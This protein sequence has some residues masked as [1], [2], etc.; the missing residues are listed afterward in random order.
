MTD[1]NRRDEFNVEPVKESTF[2]DSGFRD[3]EEFMRESTDNRDYV[4][5]E[6]K[7]K[8]RARIAVIAAS[9]VVVLAL[10]IIVFKI[11]TTD[12]SSGNTA[13]TPSPS[14]NST[15]TAAP[16][17]D[18][19][20]IVSLYPQ[21]PVV[22]AKQVSVGIANGTIKATD[23]TS[24]ILKGAKL[25]PPA[26]Q[27]RITDPT[28]FCLVAT[29]SGSG[30]GFDLYYLKDAAHSRLFENPASFTKVSVANSPAAGVVPINT[31]K[32]NAQAGVIVNPNSSGW[33]IVAESGGEKMASLMGTASI[34]K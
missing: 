33:M 10:S 20:P 14:A 21:A 28:E 34:G 4:E 9:I 24:L 18:K 12:D 29:G 1:T 3:D 31:G 11:F 2:G 5:I 19:N 8:R 32:E 27:C 30:V 22:V 26:Q 15:D 25:T 6:Q 13:A 7:K 23:G 17:N 16:R